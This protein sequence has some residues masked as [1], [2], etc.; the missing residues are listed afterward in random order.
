[1]GS[2]CLGIAVAVLMLVTGCGQ[3]P[4]TQQR[5][6]HYVALG[7]SYTSAPGT[8]EEVGSPPGCDRS[9][10]NY[11]RLV[12]AELNPERFTDASCSGATT[13]DITSPQPTRDGT[14]PP[15]LN[16]VRPET[17][18]ITIGIG[19]ND[20]GLVALAG[21]CAA[22]QGSRSCKQRLTEGGTDELTARI[23][24]AG[25]AVGRVL[26]RINAKA[27]DAR[28]VVVGY[29]TILPADPAACP[30]E[31]PYAEADIAY[32]RRGLQR[33]NTVLAEQARQHGAE[34][35]D[36]AKASEGH[37][38]CAPPDS[39]WIE[40]PRSTTGA[41]PLHPNAR[42]ERAMARAVLRELS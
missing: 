24:R 13:R 15:Q 7:D 10:N 12:A 30:P 22:K 32:L 36:T 29:P 4:D 2:K 37:G 26:E 8:G 40:G 27:P 41:A 5:P 39:R 17:T 6:Q 11:P 42:G 3:P 25:E 18:L 14:N 1:M 20:V 33:L 31:L 19:G 28:V 21:E 34:F 9:R 38:M 23:E 35:A 16:A